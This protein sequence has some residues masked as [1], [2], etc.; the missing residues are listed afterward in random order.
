M[1]GKAWA[2]ARHTAV[3]NGLLPAASSFVLAERVTEASICV[4]VCVKCEKVAGAMYR[5][6]SALG[7]TAMTEFCVDS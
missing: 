3:P 6:H 1:P 5:V 2:G 4:S 7:K